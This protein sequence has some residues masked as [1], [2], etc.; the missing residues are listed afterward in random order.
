[1]HLAPEHDEVHIN[2]GR[3]MSNLQYP[4]VINP[5]YEWGLYGAAAMHLHSI[6]RLILRGYENG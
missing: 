3:F 2:V 1:M 6:L 4:I 5:K